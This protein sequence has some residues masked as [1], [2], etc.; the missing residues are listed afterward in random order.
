MA[1]LRDRLNRESRK[2]LSSLVVHRLKVFVVLL[3]TSVQEYSTHD[4]VRLAAATAFFTTFA[5]APILLIIINILGIIYNFEIVTG[6]IYS[7][8]NDIVGESAALQIQEIANN[9]TDLNTNWKNTILGAVFLT[10]VSTTLFTVVRKSLNQIWHVTERKSSFLRQMKDRGLGVLII[11]L[12]GL[13]FMVTLLADT[14]VNL[15]SGYISRYTPGFTIAFLSFSSTVTSV[16]IVT[17]WFALV[18]KYLPAIKSRWKPTLVGALLTGVFFTIGKSILGVVLVRGNLSSLYGAGGSLVLLLLFIFYS[19]L[20]FY[21]GA[22]FTKKLAEYE[23][24]RT[25]PKRYAVRYRIIR[26][27]EKEKGPATAPAKQE[28]E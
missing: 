27:G 13:L 23:N 12:I 3:K 24:I 8:L 6:E 2:K 25:P 11:L 16:F 28:Y 18:F 15:L 21:F 7:R 17:V 4:P 22:C 26:E 5:L 10:F 19:S 9:F 1:S 14:I 20:I